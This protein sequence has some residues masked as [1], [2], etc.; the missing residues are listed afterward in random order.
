MKHA[1]VC[2]VC[3]GNGKIPQP[4][5][6]EILDVALPRDDT[7]RLIV[8]CHGCGGKGWVEVGD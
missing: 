3:H 1:E 6:H 8:T 2:P 4:P 7:G 5:F